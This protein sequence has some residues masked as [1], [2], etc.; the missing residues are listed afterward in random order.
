VDHTFE[1]IRIN[2]TGE[3]GVGRSKS[4]HWRRDGAGEVVFRRRRPVRDEPP[5]FNVKRCD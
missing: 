1:K 3:T 4:I 2:I 5:P